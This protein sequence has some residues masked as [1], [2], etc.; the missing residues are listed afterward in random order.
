LAA[1]LETQI[2]FD[3][4][5]RTPGQVNPEMR[6]LAFEMDRQALRHESRRLGK[7]Q[8]N[9]SRPAFDR[10][11]QLGVPVLI[12]VGAQDQ[13]YAH[14]SAAYMMN[15]IPSARMIV[16]EDAAHLPNMDQPDRFREAVEEFLRGLQA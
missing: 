7:R 13:P 6:K 16:I 12:I 15:H 1:E 2:W 5:G 4:E 3:G 9:S 11:H 14:A 10:L 8:P